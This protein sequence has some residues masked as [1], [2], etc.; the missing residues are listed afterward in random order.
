MRVTRREEV[1]PPLGRMKRMSVNEDFE[2]I[3]L[4]LFICG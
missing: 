4:I 1:A 3:L 2:F